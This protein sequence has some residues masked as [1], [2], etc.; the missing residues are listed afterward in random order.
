MVKTVGDPV[1][2][3][4]LHP[5]EASEL[6][7]DAAARA[8]AGAGRAA[9]PAIKLPATLEVIFRNADLAD[10]ATWIV[11]VERGSTAPRS[12]M[13]DDDPIAL[14]RTF[15]TVVQLTRAIVE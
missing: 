7:R 6:I 14:F 10:M 13:T 9:P 8:I 11:G 4:V 12:R 15:I 2:R 3:G 1:R 5:D